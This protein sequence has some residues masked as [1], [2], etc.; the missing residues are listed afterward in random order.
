MA[1]HIKDSTL[2]FVLLLLTGASSCQTVNRTLPPSTAWQATPLKR[3][4]TAAQIAADL[5]SL[6]LPAP[7]GRIIFIGVHGGNPPPW[8]EAEWFDPQQWLPYQA[9]DLEDQRAVTEIAYRE[10]VMHVAALQI[11]RYFPNS[12]TIMIR[13]DSQVVSD[14]LDAIYRVGDRI[15]LVG[16]S[17]GGRVVEELARDLKRRRIVVDALVYIESFWSNG[18]VPNNV[19]RALNFYVPAAFTF[20]RGLETIKAEDPIGTKAINI[21][22]PNPHGPYDG[23]CAEHRNIDSDP[24]VWKGIF[25][26]VITKIDVQQSNFTQPAILR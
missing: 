6:K 2:T 16:H 5:P 21:A 3:V 1:Y 11:G 17:F 18:S 10:S 25:D 20:C 23:L 22:I 26:Y 13:G 12:I 9:I 4:S 7:A 14:L 8:E 15:L 19:K 24:R